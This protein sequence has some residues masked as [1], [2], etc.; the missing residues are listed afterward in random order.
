MRTAPPS[1]GAGGATAASGAGGGGRHLTAAASEWGEFLHAPG[2][3]FTDFGRIRA[4][5]QAETDRVVGTNKG[6]SDKP[7]RLRIYSPHVLTMTL[8]RVVMV[9]GA[10]GPR[11]RHCCCACVCVYDLFL[12]HAKGAVAV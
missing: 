10:G 3:E 2:R 9:V 4:E 6:V 5:I 7:I 1:G 11:C 8:V 12:L